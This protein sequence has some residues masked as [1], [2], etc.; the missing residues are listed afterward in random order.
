MTSRPLIPHPLSSVLVP[1]FAHP[2]DDV[3]FT[4]LVDQ[5]IV[6]YRFSEA[7]SRKEYNQEQHGNDRDVIRFADNLKK[8]FHLRVLSRGV[9]SPGSDGFEPS[10]DTPALSTPYPV[11][12]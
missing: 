12:D 10:F 2:I 5:P 8:V 7:Q 1:L 9:L 6:S 11:L 3:F 4:A